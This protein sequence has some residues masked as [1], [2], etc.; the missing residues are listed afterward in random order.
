VSGYGGRRVESLPLE[1]TL[2]IC[3]KHNLLREGR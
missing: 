1:K 2:E 3:R